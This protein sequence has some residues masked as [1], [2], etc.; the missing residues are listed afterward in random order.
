MASIVFD[1]ETLRYSLDTFDEKQQEY[2]FK[3]CKTEEERTT[4]IQ[5]LAL[6]AFTARIIA[7]GMVNPETH[8]GK[9]IFIAEK[10]ETFRNNDELV[11]YCSV[12]EEKDVLLQF[13]NDIK[14]FDQIITFNGRNFDCP[15]LLLRSAILNIHPTR[16]LMP[17]RYDADKHCDLLEQLTFYGAQK[18]MNLDFICKSFGITS[19]KENGITGL[20]LPPLFEQKRFREIAEYCIGDVYATCELY[21][22]W[23]EFLSQQGA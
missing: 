12:L 10:K 6:N 11:E 16:N 7:V 18:R 5:E 21:R 14:H 17:Y 19:P 9:V 2:L 3:F 23:K 13:W 20:E 8:R 15:F 4:K 1:I 22:R